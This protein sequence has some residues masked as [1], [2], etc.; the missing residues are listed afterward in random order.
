MFLSNNKIIN[1]NCQGIVIH[2]P[3]I[4][5]DNEIYE[6]GYKIELT[7]GASPSYRGH[8]TIIGDELLQQNTSQNIRFINEV[9]TFQL[10][11]HSQT[12]ERHNNQ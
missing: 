1:P 9:D 3:D 7:N 12:Y 10:N 8:R 2:Q 11:D 4:F 5:F 6:Y